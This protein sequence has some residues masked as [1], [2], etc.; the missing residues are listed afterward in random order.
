MT[1][2]LDTDHHERYIGQ[3][4]YH[5]SIEPILTIDC[6]NNQKFILKYVHEVNFND[7]QDI[8]SRRSGG[9]NH[10]RLVKDTISDKSMFV[11]QYSDD[12][13]LQ[14]AQKDLPIGTTK[15]IL[16]DGLCGIAELHDQDIIYTDLKADNVLINWKECRNE[17]KIE[18]VQL[19]DLED[20]VYIPPGSHIIGKQVGNWMWRSPEAHARGPVDKPSDMFSFAL[21]CIY[22]VHKRVIFTVGEEELDEGVEPLAVVIQRQIS[23]FADEEGMGGFLRHLG[24][25]PRVPIFEVTRNGFNK[26]NPRKPFS[27]WEGVDEDFKDLICAL[28]NFNPEK[29]IT[30]REALAHKWF[31][32]NGNI[33][34]FSLEQ[35]RDSAGAKART[36]TCLR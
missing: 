36:A 27:F 6:A 1:Y 21:V 26:D 28:T 23:Y 32:D 13:L 8:N 24:D 35:R 12:H 9:A 14:L 4:G 11:F 5:Y 10:V 29:R 22:A 34:L 2:K 20:A 33:V 15:R 17:I 3:S 18:R 25:N 7:L 31:E 30:A 19:A 16:K